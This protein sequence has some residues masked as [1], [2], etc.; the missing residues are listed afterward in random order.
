ML[1][2]I[3][4]SVTV[5]TVMVCALGMGYPQ[6]NETQAEN[7]AV[8]ETL[9][10]TEIVSQTN[11]SQNDVN[12]VQEQ[13]TKA[14]S[15]LAEGEAIIQ[16]STV[17]LVESIVEANKRKTTLTDEEVILLQKVVSAE[18]RGES[19]EAQYN[20]ACVILNRLESSFFPDSLEE[21][22]NQ[23][24]QFSCV[25][26]GA[27]LNV[28]ITE[29]VV[30]AVASALDNNTLDAKVMWFRSNHYHPFHKNAFQIGQM[31]FSTI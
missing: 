15:Q 11:T 29:S 2:R 17:P 21:V 20:V 12:L 8:V 13:G 27:I 30:E 31:F 22:V 14:I 25:E 7:V 5:F 23:S 10:K 16:D 9:E 6:E 28:P 19:S 4:G 24:G 26:S 1:K 3:V 18:S